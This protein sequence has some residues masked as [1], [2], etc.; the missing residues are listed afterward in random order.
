[1][2]KTA[3]ALRRCV[4]RPGAARGSTA[5]RSRAP[6]RR[7]HGGAHR[8]IPRSTNPASRRSSVGAL[9]EDVPAAAPAAQ[10]DVGTEAVDEPRVAAARVGRRRRTTSPRS[11]VQDG[12]VRHRR[13]RVSKP[14]LA[15]GRDEVTI[16]RRQRRAAPSASPSTTTSGCVA[17]SWAMTPPDRVSEPVSLSGAPIASRSNGSLDRRPVDRDRTGRAD[18][19]DARHEPDAADRRSPRRRVAQLVHELLERRAVDR[20]ADRDRHA[21]ARSTGSRPA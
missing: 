7:R 4:G 8:R 20:A 16:V 21:R 11:S 9:D 1:M 2:R 13:V 3:R 17:A 5:S 14:G 15:V 19:D 6:G 12:S 10:A 18:H